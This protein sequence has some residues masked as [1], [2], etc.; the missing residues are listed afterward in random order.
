MNLELKHIAPYLPY[1]LRGLSSR[2]TIFYLGTGSN[3]L[4]KG[5]ETRGIEIWLGGDIRPILRPLSDLTKEIEDIGGKF[6]LMNYIQKVHGRRVI[7]QKIKF[8]DLQKLLL[9]G[10]YDEVPYW[11]LEYLFSH[12]FDVFGLIDNGL[13]ID[14]NTI[15]T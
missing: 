1:G 5:V 10:I 13:A 2:G 11:A 15:K 7:Y 6:I 4:G 8:W 12:H 3:M 14:I 9:N